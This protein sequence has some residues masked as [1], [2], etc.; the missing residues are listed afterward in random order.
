MAVS[1]CL[2]MGAWALAV[3]YRHTTARQQC[4]NGLVSLYLSSCTSTAIA[5]VTRIV[6]GSTL[7]RHVQ[8]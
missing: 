8:T 4:I 7:G 5:A 6:G 1:L 3:S 2:C